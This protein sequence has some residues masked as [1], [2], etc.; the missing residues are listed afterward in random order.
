MPNRGGGDG[1]LA[2]RRPHLAPFPL[3][4]RV[5]SAAAGAIRRPTLWWLETNRGGADG[6]LAGRRPHLAV[7]RLVLRVGSATAW[8]ISRE[9]LWWLKTHRG[10]ANSTRSVAAIRP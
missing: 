8:S 1:R 6:R 2:G 3:G 7:V 9:T 5:G 4:L 10:D